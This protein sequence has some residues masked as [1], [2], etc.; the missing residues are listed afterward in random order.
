MVVV[1]CLK[2]TVLSILFGTESEKPV[3]PTEQIKQQ[4]MG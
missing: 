1:G 3:P 4:E 2:F